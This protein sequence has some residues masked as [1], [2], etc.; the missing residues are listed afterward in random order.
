MIKTTTNQNQKERTMKKRIFLLSWLLALFGQHAHAATDLQATYSVISS[1]ATG[2]VAAVTLTNTSN[3][4]VTSWAVNFSLAQGQAVNCFWNSTPTQNGQ[5]VS[6]VNLPTNGTL[7]PGQ[8]ITMGFQINGTGANV[9]NGLAA[10]GTSGTSSGT[11]LSATATTTTVW[12]TAYQVNVTLTNNTAQPTSSWTAQF[13]LPAGNVLSANTTNGIFTTSG[14]TVTVKNTASNGTIA[15]GG[16]TTFSMIINMP[17]SGVTTISNLQAAANG[18]ITPIELTAPTLQAISNSNGANQYAVSWTSV[19][20][21]TNYLLQSSTNSSFSNPTTVYNGP[22]TSFSVNRQAAGTYFYRVIATAGNNMSNPSNLQSVTVTQTPPPVSAGFENSMWAEDWTNNLDAPVYIQGLPRGIDTIHVFVGQLDID[23]NGNPTING[24]T[25]DTP[26][27]PAGTGAFPNIAAL[28]HFIAQC[29]AQGVT[30]KLSIGGTPATGF[31]LSWNRLTSSNI[32]GFAQAL[33]N[34][35][36]ITGADGIDFDYELEDNAN[37]VLA[38]R[39]A[40]QFKDLAPNLLTSFCVYAG[41]D[42]QG[43]WHQID[44]I[45]LENAIRSNGT[46][47]IDR[48]YVMSYYDGVTLEQNKQFM[49]LWKTWLQQHY[50]FS[51]LQISAGVDPNDPNTSPNNGTLTAWIDFAAQNNFSVAIWDQLGINDY[52][53]HNWGQV[54]RTIYTQ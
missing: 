44:S 45:F 37:A 18:P 48:V 30:V 33:V 22:A 50:G 34:I 27:R 4:P 47:A 8:S 1:W 15:P 19:A 13:T 11:N 46:S 6:A 16:S 42:A 52:I 51:S 31:G 7:Q 20:N 14:Q 38:G 28:T 49:L 25:A 32:A 39:L 36:Q 54:I 2:Y 29:K 23:S 35:C 5:N 17:Q 41:I 24:F 10:S 21:A 9:L 12:A 3:A 53:T 26:G 43:P 40:A